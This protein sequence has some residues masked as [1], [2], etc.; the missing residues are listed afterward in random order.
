VSSAIRASV[1]RATGPAARARV[2]RA[3]RIA[4]TMITVVVIQGL[5]CGAALLPVVLIGSVAVAASESSSMRRALTLAAI[6]VPSYVLFALLLMFASAVTGRALKWQTPP[7]AHMRIADVDWPLLQW[8]RSL[9]AIHVVRFFAGALFRGTPIWTAYLRLA[10][11]RLGRRVYVNSLALTDYNLL[12]VGDDV[13]IGDG[14]H[15]SGHTVEGGF[16]K[17]AALRIGNNVTVGLGSVIEIDV[18]VGEDCQIGALSFVPKHARLEKGAIFAGIPVER[19]GT[20]IDARRDRS[21]PV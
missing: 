2:R 20:E 14:V 17:T 8:A 3:G 1:V 12:E 21:G 4:W 9:I 18:E 11:A 10:G 7:N 13:V 15:A 6:A 19:I 5:V 16:V